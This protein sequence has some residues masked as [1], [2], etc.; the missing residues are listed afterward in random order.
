MK[1]IGLYFIAILLCLFQA[2]AWDY[3]VDGELNDWGVIPFSD[4]EP[5]SDTADYI[6]EDFGSGADRPWGG[7]KWDIEA[8]YFDNNYENAYFAIITSHPN[9]GSVSTTMGDLALDINNDGRYEY[10]IKTTGGN[11]GQICYKPKWKKKLFSR[12]PATFRCNGANSQVMPDEALVI[13]KQADQYDNGY[14]NYVIEVEASVNSLG[15]P[16]NEQLSNAHTSMS[17]LNDVIELE[18][19]EWDFDVPEFSVIG[20]LVVLIGAGIFISRK[21]N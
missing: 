3:T 8:M 1:R 17:C 6:V 19:F 4:W 16:T 12:G 2:S 15:N 14:A 18:P 7:E 21:R 9:D 11:K 5:T 13:W 20:A 10:G